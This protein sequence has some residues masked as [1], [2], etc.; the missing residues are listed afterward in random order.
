M[1][2]EKILLL[3]IQYCTVKNCFISEKNAVLNFL[4]TKND[5]NRPRFINIMA[6]LL[7]ENIIKKANDSARYVIL[8]ASGLINNRMPNA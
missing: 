8:K 7:P 5:N 1:E 4:I 6:V 2:I 3:C